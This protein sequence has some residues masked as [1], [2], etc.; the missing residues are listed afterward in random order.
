MPDLSTDLLSQINSRDFTDVLH[1]LLTVTVKT[2]TYASPTTEVMRYV[3]AFDDVV[4]DGNTYTAGEFLIGAPGSSSDSPPRVTLTADLGDADLVAKFQ[5]ALEKPIVKLEYILASKVG[6]PGY[7]PEPEYG[8]F[9][10]QV[11]DISF[12]DTT[13]QASLTYEP[14]LQQTIPR[15]FVTPTLFPGGF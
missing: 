11:S 6:N 14:I 13:I 9:E 1:P 12:Q 8:P 10:F 3:K 7:G 15:D 4:F 5:L 2:G